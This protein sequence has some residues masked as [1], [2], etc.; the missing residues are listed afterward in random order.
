MTLSTRRLALAATAALLALA[1]A[2]TVMSAPSPEV[3]TTVRDEAFR[4]GMDGVDLAAITGP[5]TGPKGSASGRL[6]A[7]ADPARRGDLRPC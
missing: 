1:G 2:Q 5:T 6:P 7:C 3:Q 4:P